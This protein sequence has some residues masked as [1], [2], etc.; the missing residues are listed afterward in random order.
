MT[1]IF[2]DALARRCNAGSR[3]STSPETAEELA[4]TLTREQLMR[5]M[6]TMETLQV[7]LRR[8]MNYTLF[9]TVFCAR[10]REA[11]GR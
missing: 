4:R 3:L 9:L 1:L 2:R 5:L 7:A 6:E 11:A 10:L 8:N